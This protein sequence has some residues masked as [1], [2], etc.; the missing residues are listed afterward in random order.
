MVVCCG[1]QCNELAKWLIETLR[2][3]IINSKLI[4][5]VFTVALAVASYALAV[6]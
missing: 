3:T 6:G 5:I 4:G 1:K 2:S